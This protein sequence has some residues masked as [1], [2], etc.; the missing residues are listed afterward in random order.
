MP[1]WVFN[2][3][4]SASSNFRDNPVLR[5]EYFAVFV[6]QHHVSPTCSTSSGVFNTIAS[7]TILNNG[8]LPAEADT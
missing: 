5:C 6:L 1:L 7:R 2:N 3:R 4:Q 8:C